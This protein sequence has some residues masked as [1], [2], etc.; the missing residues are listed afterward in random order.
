MELIKTRE[1]MFN[2]INHD[3]KNPLIAGDLLIKDLLT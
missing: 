1:L 3:I 2:S